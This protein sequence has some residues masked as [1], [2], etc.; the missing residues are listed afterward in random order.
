VL[1]MKTTLPFAVAMLCAGS[2]LAQQNDWII[3]PG[4]RLGP[5]IPD[6]SRSDLDRLF[7]RANVQ[8]QP[9]DTGEGPEPATVVFPKMPTAA[10]AIL[11]SQTA[12]NRVSDVLI[13]FQSLASPCKWH[14]EN[15]VS[16]GTTLEKLE[17][18]NGRAFQI[19][20]WGFDGQGYISSWLGGKLA[21]VFD[22]GG[23]SWYGFR[24]GLGL[25]LYYQETPKDTTP[26]QRRLLDQTYRLKRIP[27]STD[28][29][30]RQ[31]HLKVR[32]MKLV[33]PSNGRAPGGK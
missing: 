21:N 27:L 19:Q 23:Q 30:M 26:Q 25:R 17:T 33:F 22:D 3:V 31:L 5:I 18:L 12:P 7:G 32:N 9:V 20:P 6:T 24:S 11:W 8:D 16:L 29:F 14:T 2:A 13:C 4:K 15:G 1:R 10:L 28:P